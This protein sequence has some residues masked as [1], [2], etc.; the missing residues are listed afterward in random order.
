MVYFSVYTS[1][2]S[3]S[4]VSTVSTTPRCP[5]AEVPQPRRQQQLGLGVS[6]PPLPPAGYLGDH[7]LVTE[8]IRVIHFEYSDEYTMKA[9]TNTLS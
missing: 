2:A 1:A 5:G 9:A 6:P 4:T 7:V 8:D 3:L